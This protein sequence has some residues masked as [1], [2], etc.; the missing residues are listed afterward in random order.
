MF[1]GVNNHVRMAQWIRRPP[2]EREILRSN[3]SA[4]AY[5]RVAQG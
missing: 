2:T 4:D 5:G 3:R 1:K